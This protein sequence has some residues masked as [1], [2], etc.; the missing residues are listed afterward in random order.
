MKRIL[1]LVLLSVSIC[2]FF[3]CGDDDY[4]GG[5]AKRNNQENTVKFKLTCNTQ[6]VP[7]TLY[8]WGDYLIIK[9]SWEGECVTKQY[10]VLF[11]AICRDE[12]ALLTG[13][14]YVNGKLV[15]KAEGNLITM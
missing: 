6:D 8:G 15:N 13:E 9:N 4:D 2:A 11:S 7:V 12:T 10:K 3:S 14:I 1:M 5:E